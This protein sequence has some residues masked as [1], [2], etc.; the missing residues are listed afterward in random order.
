MGKRLRARWIVVGVLVVAAAAAC[1]SSSSTSSGG[2]TGTTTPSATKTVGASGGTVAT[3]DGSLT[4]TIPAGALSGDTEITIAE[5]NSPP[6]D[7]IGKA[8]EI[9]PT[10]TQFASPV[11]L[12]FKYAGAN[13]MGT[14]PSD[15]EAATIVGTDWVAL[16]N[17]A[18]DTNAQI[19]SG[20]TMHLS[21]Y[22]VHAKGH[23]QKDASSGGDDATTSTDSSTGTDDVST[24]DDGASLD[25]GS[26]A[27]G[28]CSTMMYQVSVCANRPLQLQCP[29]GT[30]QLSCTDKGMNM[31]GFT[32][33]C[34]PNDGG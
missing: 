15:L 7:A 6:S 11:T 1:S 32:L 31:Q 16:T 9:G 2:G 20:T 8:Y 5:I 22:G 34:C 29:A 30:F 18:V 23:G 19:A 21:P 24:A 14:D 12:S 17:D 3:P 28:N 13:L 33:V 10:G 27:Y 25:A 4:V 26:D